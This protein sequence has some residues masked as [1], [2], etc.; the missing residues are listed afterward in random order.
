MATRIFVPVALLALTC[1]PSRAFDQPQVD[2]VR[3]VKSERILELRSGG[4]LVRRYA[5]ALGGDPVGR[6]L[7]E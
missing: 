5:I 3:V 7:R 6:K 4:K 1:L 2:L